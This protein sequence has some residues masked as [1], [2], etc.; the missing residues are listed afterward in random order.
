MEVL[1]CSRGGK[2]APSN[3]TNLLMLQRLWGHILVPLLQEPVAFEA[4]GRM[5]PARHADYP[6]DTDACASLFLGC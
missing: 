5:I 6:S 2:S 1:S 4:L 3:V